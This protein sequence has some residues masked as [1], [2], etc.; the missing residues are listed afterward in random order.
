MRHSVT[1]NVVSNDTDS[2]RQPTVS[3]VT[4][5]RMAR[6][7]AVAAYLFFERQLNGTDSFTYGIRGNA[8]QLSATVN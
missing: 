4:Q 1:V 5:G 3:A 7:F 6:D 8:A 2:G